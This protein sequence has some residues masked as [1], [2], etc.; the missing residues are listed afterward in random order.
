MS[1]TEQRTETFIKYFNDGMS[2]GLIEKKMSGVTRNALIGKAHRLGLSRNKK[3]PTQAIAHRERRP[4][5]VLRAAPPVPHP[6]FSPV[7]VAPTPMPEPD[8][9]DIAIPAEQRRTLMQLT[10]DTCRW[11]VGDPG[12]PEFFF[13]GARPLGESPYCAAHRRMAYQPSQRAPARP[14]RPWLGKDA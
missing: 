3:A 7:P 4:R 12:T 13:C 5:V 8:V 14:F 2:F 10:D 9:V 1:W 6:N 11:P